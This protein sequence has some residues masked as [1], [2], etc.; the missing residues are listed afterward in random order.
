MNCSSSFAFFLSASI[1]SSL[2]ASSIG[3]SSSQGNR[4]T[5]VGSSSLV[6]FTWHIV[7]ISMRVRSQ[8]S[9]SRRCMPRKKAAHSPNDME[10]KK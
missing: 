7:Y 9:C 1:S 8:A 4:S 6:E 5:S 2:A 10:S 3:A